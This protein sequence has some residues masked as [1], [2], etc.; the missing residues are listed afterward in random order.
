MTPTT[1][2]CRRL[3]IVIAA[4]SWLLIGLAIPASAH[5]LGNFSVNQYHGVHLYSDRFTDH[6]VLDAAEIPTLQAVKQVDRDG[7]GDA[8]VSERAAYAAD[9]CSALAAAVRVTVR[10]DRLRLSVVSSSYAYR[11][12]LVNFQTSR[13]VCELSAR[14]DLTRPATVTLDSEGVSPGVGWREITAVGT[15]V[16]IQDSPVPATSISGT[17]L[18]YPSDL[19]SAPLDVR[20]VSLSTVPGAGASTYAGSQQL[21]GGD[22]T[23]RALDGLTEAINGVVGREHL[24]LAVGLLGVALALLLGAAHAA[25]PGHGKT[26]M[27]AYLVGHSGGWRDVLTVGAT[28][29]LTHTAGVLVLGLLISV[30]ATFAP[31]RALSYLG[32]VSGLLIVGVGVGLLWSAL[33]R[34][35]RGRGAS[36]SPVLRL[37][38]VEA[39]PAGGGDRSGA[40]VAVSARHHHDAPDVAQRHAHPH[41]HP[42][43]HPPAGPH[44]DPH[45]HSHDRDSHGHGFRR[46]GLVGLGVAGGL[47]PSPSAL[48]VLLAAIPLGHTAFG[49]ALV[50]CYGIGMA[51]ALIAAGLVL[52]RVRNRVQGSGFARRF[53]KAQRYVQLLPVLTALLV[54]IVGVGLTARSA[55]LL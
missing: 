2:L 28:V 34:R 17:L 20:R 38:A 46:S 39:A 4:S 49:I 14:V 31:T 30:S 21:P 55:S 27:A 3:A 35:L 54:V 50:L 8:T 15:G 23:P 12:G 5:P 41:A 16:S 25:L 6:A 48:L 11:P 43:P 29:T 42:H 40:L 26:V 18:R 32:V 22:L 44:A 47:V 45:G 7:T 53:A 9:R 1:R 33:L 37:D 13:L 52:V 10:G 24:T 36:A 51:G 19:L